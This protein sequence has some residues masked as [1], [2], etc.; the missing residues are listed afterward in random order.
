[1]QAMRANIGKGIAA[2]VAGGL[3]AAWVME[4]FQA[5]LPRVRQ[6]IAEPQPSYIYTGARQSSETTEPATVKAAAA[7]SSTVLRRRLRP[8]EKEVAGEVVHYAV[9]AIAGG[10]YGAISEYLPEVRL[11]AGSVF[12][13]TLWA[14]SDEIGVPLS[15]LSRPPQD[16]PLRV[17]ASAL[18]A[19]LVY[20]LSTELLRSALRRG[21]LAK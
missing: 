7:I 16:Y 14:L 11:G 10:V 3:I 17:H 5:A 1:M 8:H 6:T 18:G 20:G 19:H 21:V 9:G 12:G 4:R 15:G 2:G 13:A